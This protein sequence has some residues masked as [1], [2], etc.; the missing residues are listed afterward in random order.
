MQG[1]IHLIQHGGFELVQFTGAPPQADF[2]FQLKA[3]AVPLELVELIALFQLLDQGR[4][5]PL[6]VAH[7]VAHDF[8]GVGR[9]HQ[10]QIQI[11]QQVFQLG[12]RHIQTAEALKQLTKRGWLVLAGQGRQERIADNGLLVGFEAVEIAVFLDVL[13]ENV[14]QLEIEGE[15]PGRGDGLSQIH[16]PDQL[17]DGGVGIV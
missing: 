14:D 1:V 10:P 2:L 12:G 4:H 15:R 16:V 11:A 3:Q 5:A 17:H 9:K 8:G 7:R 6:L 13:L